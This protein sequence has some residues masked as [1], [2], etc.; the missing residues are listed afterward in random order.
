[1]DVSLTQTHGVIASLPTDVPGTITCASTTA[2]VADSSTVESEMASRCEALTL[3]SPI[4]NQSL[5]RT[6]ETAPAATEGSSALSQDPAVAAEGQANEMGDGK[7]QPEAEA[8]AGAAE[9]AAEGAAKG[10]PAA[11]AQTASFTFADILCDR[12][13]VPR[14]VS[15]PAWR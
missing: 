14:R 6:C 11:A 7:A 4:P 3:D 13:D 1:M 5:G 10:A 12:G 9:L 8:A 2:N 15:S